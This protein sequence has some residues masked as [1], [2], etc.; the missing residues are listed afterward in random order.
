VQTIH[1]DEQ[2]ALDVMSAFERAFIRVC[3]RGSVCIRGKAAQQTD[4]HTCGKNSQQHRDLP[5]VA[6][7]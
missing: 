7:F 1:A 4:A 2:N 3:I 6:S 5:W